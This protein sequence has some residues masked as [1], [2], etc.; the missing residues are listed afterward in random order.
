MMTGGVAQRWLT[1]EQAA[2]YTGFAKG[3]LYNK[4][5][6]RRTSY[7]LDVDVYQ[8]GHH[9][10]DNGMTR[11]LVTAMSPGISVFSIGAWDDGVNPFRQRKRTSIATPRLLGG[12][13][14]AV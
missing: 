9:R 10:V 6:N 13:Q 12:W 11:P 8:V 4:V 14:A 1:F 5:S 2:T 7:L 3:T